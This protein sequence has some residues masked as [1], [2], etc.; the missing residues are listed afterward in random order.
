[1]IG[2]VS[3]LAAAGGF[4]GMGLEPALGKMHGGGDGPKEYT[5]PELPYAYDALEPTIDAQT[6]KLHHDKHH[7]GYVKGLNKALSRLQRIRQSGSEAD[8]G[9]APDVTQDLAFNGS[10]HVLHTL[11]WNCLKPGGSKV[12]DSLKKHIDKCFGSMDNMKAQMMKVTTSVSGSGWGI[13]A[14]EPMGKRLI[15]LGAHRHENTTMWGCIPL[16]VVDV[17][18]HAYYLKYQNNRGEYVKQLANIINY[19]Y[20]A[21]RLD[22]AM[23]M[24]K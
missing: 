18:E 17:W 16:K 21:Q 8:M 1:M 9:M 24:C 23:K 14:F 3:A 6:L 2:S 22:M 15:I 10:G 20:V 4:L 12:P 7:A 5:L 13:L 19:D 11:Y